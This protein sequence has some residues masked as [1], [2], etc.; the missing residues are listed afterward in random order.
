M[1]VINDDRFIK[2]SRNFREKGTNRQH[3]LEGNR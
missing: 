2:K 3:F 1:L